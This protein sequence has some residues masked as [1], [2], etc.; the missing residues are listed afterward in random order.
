MT[1]PSW[2]SR[3]ELGPIAAA[4][5]T[6][7]H[8]WREEQEALTA[9]AAEQFHHGRTVRS[10]LMECMRNGDRVAVVS[11]AHRAVGLI[12]EIADDL[13]AVRN[14]GSGRLDFRLADDLV[15]QVVV[16]ERAIGQPG[17]D[18]LVS[19]S[20]R[21][22]LLERESADGESTI[23]SLLTPEPLDGKLIVGADH[24]RVVGRGGGETILPIQSIA[25]VGP[26]RD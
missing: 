9:D 12:V 26:R 19:G 3:P 1:T 21:A 8:E 4:A 14:L 15:F 20:F 24:V 5:T 2:G 10:L 16:Q 6:A 22:R 23:G 17:G 11:G 25:Y 18:E 7:R 13:I